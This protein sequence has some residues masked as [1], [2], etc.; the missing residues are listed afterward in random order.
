MT[1]HTVHPPFLET[2]RGC[3]TPGSRLADCLSTSFEDLQVGK[4]IPFISSIFWCFI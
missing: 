2:I 4:V 1:L 3:V